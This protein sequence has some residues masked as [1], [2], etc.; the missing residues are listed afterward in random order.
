MSEEMEDWIASQ[1][2]FERAVQ[3]RD[4]AEESLQS[5]YRDRK[6]SALVVAKRLGLDEIDLSA[7][8]HFRYKGHLFQIAR[9]GDG[10][11]IEAI[12]S[13]EIE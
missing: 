1:L 2:T 9:M 11:S 4:Q 5:A 10:A 8:P 7:E 13:L 3:R 6:A 12:E